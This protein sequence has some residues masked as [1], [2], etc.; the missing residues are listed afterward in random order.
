MELGFSCSLR[1]TQKLNYPPSNASQLLF[2]LVK[3]SLSLTK[4]LVSIK[5]FLIQT[6]ACDHLS[7]LAPT[8]LILR[9][10]RA[11]R[12]RNFSVKI[13]LERFLGLVFLKNLPAAHNTFHTI[14]SLYYFRRARKIKLVDLK[15]D[16]KICNFFF[17]KH[18]PPP[19]ENFLRTPLGS[20]YTI[21]SIF[22]TLLFINFP[23]I[24]H[25]NNNCFASLTHWQKNFWKK[26]WLI[27]ALICFH[28]PINLVYAS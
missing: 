26:S 27:L 16:H 10:E 25:K 13:F 1:K 15:K 17:R 28:F 7:F 23:F 6:V 5:C 12:K 3:N 9:G 11:P 21:S 8:W 18:P 4:E 2:L 20:S 22:Q 19:P 14:G 24:I